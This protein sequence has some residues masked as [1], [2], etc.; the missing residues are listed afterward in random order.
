MAPLGDSTWPTDSVTSGRYS[1]QLGR[2]VNQW[3]V[4]TWPSH[5]LPHGNGKI[6]NEGRNRFSKL[7]RGISNDQTQFSKIGSS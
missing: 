2:Q 7:K 6:P 4:T 5:G 1:Q 3:M